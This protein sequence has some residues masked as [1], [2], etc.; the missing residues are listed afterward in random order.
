MYTYIIYI[1]TFVENWRCA[2]WAHL[3]WSAARAGPGPP[4]R[5]PESDKGGTTRK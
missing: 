4:G 5:A 2:N 1:Y 3:P